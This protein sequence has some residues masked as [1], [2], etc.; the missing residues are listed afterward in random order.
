MFA[1]FRRF[2]YVA[3]V[4]ITAAAL[5]YTRHGAGYRQVHGPGLGRRWL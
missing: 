3:A 4:A 2:N 5:I 1:L